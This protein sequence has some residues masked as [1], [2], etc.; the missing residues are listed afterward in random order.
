MTTATVLP[1]APARFHSGFDLNAFAYRRNQAVSIKTEIS[2]ND[3]QRMHTLK[4]GTFRSGGAPAWAM[5]DAILRDVLTTYLER[6]AYVHSDRTLSY[7]ERLARAQ[8]RGV[9]NIKIAERL[10]DGYLAREKEVSPNQIQSMD[11]RIVLERRGIAAIFAAAVYL[12]YRC[13]W[14]STDIANE[15]GLKPPHCRQLFYK[16]NKVYLQMQS[17]RQHRLSRCTH[18]HADRPERKTIAWTPDKIADVLALRAN[19]WPWQ[20]I[21]AEFRT[22]PWNVMSA[23]HRHTHARV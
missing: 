23:C 16:L 15:I 3:Y 13:L 2:F 17:G 9:R 20:A 19:G 12:R 10:L 1:E 8:N 11:T 6:R 7:S 21:A 22:R 5:D 14:T 18:V 4:R